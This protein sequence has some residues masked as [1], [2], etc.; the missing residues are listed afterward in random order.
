MQGDRITPIGSDF[1]LP[2]RQAQAFVWDTPPPRW[3]SA[4]PLRRRR[5][6]RRLRWAWRSWSL[7]P[8]EIYDCKPP[9]L[10]GIGLDLT[11][12]TSIFLRRRE[13]LCFQYPCIVSIAIEIEPLVDDAL[14][15]FHGKVTASWAISESQ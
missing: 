4:P 3:P 14:L 10:P 1:H 11:P 8:C 6:S 13:E 2:T 9:A 12:L 15:H 5:R 7:C